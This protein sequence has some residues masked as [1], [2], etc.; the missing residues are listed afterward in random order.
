MWLYQCLR[1]TRNRSRFIRRAEEAF[2]SP[3][4]VI[5]GRE[6]RLIYLGVSRSAV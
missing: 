1:K 3:V 5:S 4:E 6:A 2:W